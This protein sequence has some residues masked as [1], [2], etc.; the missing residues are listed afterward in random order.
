MALLFGT[1]A[2]VKANRSQ[3]SAFE[4]QIEFA[5]SIVNEALSGS[6]GGGA[7]IRLHEDG[8]KAIGTPI[9]L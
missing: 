2:R 7:I 3:T 5:N 9:G 1:F 8:P 6:S 4:C